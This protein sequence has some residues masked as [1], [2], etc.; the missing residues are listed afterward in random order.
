[1]SIHLHRVFEVR[2]P[3]A[4]VWRFLTDPRSIAECMPGAHL[5]D[6]VDGTFVGEVTLKL[7][8]FGTT[9]NGE[10]GFR[11]LDPDG[12]S[13]LLSATASELSGDGTADVRMRSRLSERGD[14]LTQVEVR[15]GVRLG[16]RLDGPILRRLLVGASEVLLR[17]FVSCVRSRLETVSEESG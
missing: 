8:P 1:M 14:A 11:E 16:G 3:A 2:R 4:D 15:L 5:L 12:L 10:A 7:G 17:R 9:L 6:V 13:V